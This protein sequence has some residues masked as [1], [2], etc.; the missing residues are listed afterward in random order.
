MSH[1]KPIGVA[2]AISPM[3]LPC[4]NTTARPLSEAPGTDNREM[5]AAIRPDTLSCSAVTKGTGAWQFK[6][7]MERDVEGSETGS[8]L[9]DEDTITS[10]TSTDT[11]SLASADTVCRGWRT[12][13]PILLEDH[14]IGPPPRFNPGPPFDVGEVI[15]CDI[16]GHP[17]GVCYIPGHPHGV[18]NGLLQRGFVLQS[19]HPRNQIHLES[20]QML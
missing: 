8:R 15:I 14:V 20:G 16:P 9:M 11:L 18:P 1:P 6:L 3:P 19:E 7:D 10:S 5:T 4:G 17:H 13:D 12:G 2:I